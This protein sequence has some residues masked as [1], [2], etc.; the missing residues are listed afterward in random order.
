M[1]QLG[2]TGIG[3]VIAAGAGYVKS[4]TA[5]GFQGGARKIISGLLMVLAAAG[6]VLVVLSFVLPHFSD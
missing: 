2:M 5:G 4:T 6:L 3:L 1:K